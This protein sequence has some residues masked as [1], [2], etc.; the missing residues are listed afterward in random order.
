MIVPE[1]GDI[2]IVSDVHFGGFD[3]ETDREIK[4]NLHGLL[5]HC[6]LNGLKVIVLGDLFD[7]WMEYRGEWP[8]YGD[9]TLRMFGELNQREPV[10]YITGNHDCWTGPRLIEAGFDIEHEYRKLSIG[11]KNVLLAHGDGLADKGFVFPRPLLHRTLRNKTFLKAYQAVLP[12]KTGF[13]LMRAFS[14]VSKKR[15]GVGGHSTKR[16]DEWAIKMLERPEIDV[17]I[18]GHHHVPRFIKN[19]NGLYINSGNFF[20]DRSAVLYTKGRFEPVT[21]EPDANHL[22][23]NRLN[24]LNS[25]G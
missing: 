7:Y 19:N 12:P 17:V 20:R 1:P 15:E 2:L 23:A 5:E 11:G 14:T 10:L 13:A 6:I 21:W 22:K 4:K 8:R 25:H 24:D 18:C 16:I 9:D 3:P